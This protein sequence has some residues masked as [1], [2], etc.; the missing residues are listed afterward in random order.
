MEESSGKIQ[1]LDNLT[2]RELKELAGEIG[3][4]LDGG[5]ILLIGELGSGK[6]T[7]VRGLAKGLGI[8]EKIVRSPTFVIMSVYEGYKTLY[9]IDLYRLN[10]YEELFYVGIDEIL[11]DESSII[12]VEWA[13]LFPEIWED[14]EKIIVKLKITSEKTRSVEITDLTKEGKVSGILKKWK[15]EKS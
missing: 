5:L 6:T 1:K 14:N 4:S 7:F 13:D 11:N 9:H 3:A 10:D 15:K 12:A 8:D 2:E